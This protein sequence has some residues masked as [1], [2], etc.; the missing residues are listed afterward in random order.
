[1]VAY[2]V[3]YILK[4]ACGQVGWP[5]GALF[6]CFWV[7]LRYLACFTDNDAPKRVLSYRDG[8]SDVMLFIASQAV[9]PRS[10]QD[11]IP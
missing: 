9:M 11:I 10:S 6:I 2:F 4:R 1:M 7:D 8:K 5:G 3:L